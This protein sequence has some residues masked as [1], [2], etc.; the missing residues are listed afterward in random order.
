VQD[1]KELQN[2]ISYDTMISTSSGDSVRCVQAGGNGVRLP[3]DDQMEKRNLTADPYAMRPID[4]ELYETCANGTF[5]QV[6]A[7][8][9]KG[10]DPNAIHWIESWVTQDRKEY[11]GDHD[12]PIFQSVKNKDS[13]VF[14]LL[15]ERGADPNYEDGNLDQP[16]IFAVCTRR[17]TIAKRL[18]ELGNDPDQCTV[19]G[20]TPC[21][22]AALLPDTRFLKLLLA[23]GADPNAGGLGSR[24][25]ER[26]LKYGS[27]A[28]IRFLIK[29]GCKMD[30]H[31]N[32]LIDVS[33]LENI[34]ALLECGYNPNMFDDYVPYSQKKDYYFSPF[35]SGIGPAFMD[36]SWY[37]RGMPVVDFLSRE[38]RKLFLAFGAHSMFDTLE[39]ESPMYDT[40]LFPSGDDLFHYVSENGPSWPLLKEYRGRK[41]PTPFGKLNDNVYLLVSTK[42]ERKRIVASETHFILRETQEACRHDFCRVSPF[43][44]VHGKM[45]WHARLDYGDVRTPLSFVVANAFQGDGFDTY[46]K[47][48]VFR[49]RFMG[50][51]ES[52]ECLN[53]RGVIRFWGG[54]PVARERRD[55]GDPSIDHVDMTLSTMR[56]LNPCHDT[57]NPAF[58]EFTSTIEN[59]SQEKICCQPCYR[60][61]LW[62]GPLDSPASF[63]WTLLIA[64]TRVQKGYI[65]RVGDFVNGIAAMYGTFDEVSDGEPTVFEP[66]FECG[67]PEP[68]IPEEDIPKPPEGKPEDEW[69]PRRPMDYP[70]APT[71][72]VSLPAFT[73]ESFKK[74]VT[75]PEYRQ[76]I[77]ND[78]VPVVPP[79]RKRLREI[80]DE[81]DH[82]ITTDGNR[83]V[84]APHFDAIGIRHAVRDPATGETHLW[85]CI[86]WYSRWCERHGDLLVTASGD[87]CA[88]RYSIHTGDERWAHGEWKSITWGFK[89]GSRRTNFDTPSM[90]LESVPNMK[91]DDFIVLSGQCHGS[92]FQAACTR[93]GQRHTF[94]VEIQIFG[95]EWQFFKKN[96]TEKRLLELCWLFLNGG[97]A[98][99]ENEEPWKQVR[100]KGT[101]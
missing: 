72:R 23:H 5:A 101:Y 8:L 18:L 26:A 12:Y 89:K 68:P 96:V 100:M 6:K 48:G 29:H 57:K 54:N 81:I 67:D 22:A 46:S 95:M 75:Y 77:G 36:E 35:D 98:A 92:L 49:M 94:L 93:G 34:R 90:A 52:L 41:T 13:R 55:K 91:K 42:R 62:S 65:P 37:E 60:I 51:G 39:K 21:G 63:P 50:L 59:V 43:F 69:L 16:L 32:Q 84:F 2:P 33:P 7:L 70:D 40:F 61:R 15:L 20:D 88:L 76:R 86:P 71:P 3:S 14:K 82:V 38:R 28:R 24:A 11:C 45:L 99:V 27:P 78:L 97:L 4:V 56:A 10:A 85:L 87:G 83:R 44:K 58:A 47:G 1:K 30:R 31:L 80:I 25:L 66:E 73:D 9:D 19:D 53:N 64:K 79:S 74:F 17:Y